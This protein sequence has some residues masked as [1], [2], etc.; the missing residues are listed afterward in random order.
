MMDGHIWCHSTPNKGSVFAFTARFKIDRQAAKEDKTVKKR[1]KEQ[2]KRRLQPIVGARI[3]LTEDNEVN[4]LVASRIL[5]NAGFKVTI[6]NNGLEAVNL[7]QKEPFELV[8]MDIQMPEMDG[9]TAAKTIRSLPGF[10]KIPIVAMTAHA[11]S[12]DR[13]MSLSAGMNDHVSKPINISE[14]FQAL[15]KWI[16]PKSQ[17]EKSEPPKGLLDEP[18]AKIGEGC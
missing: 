9:L 15:I 8:L 14:L 3:L 17:L 4:Q 11:M 1:T 5:N 18:A 6:A 12:G 13:E 16:E 7:V 2:E 10:D